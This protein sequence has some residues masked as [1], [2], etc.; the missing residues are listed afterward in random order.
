M[1]MNRR[2]TLALLGSA[3]V[4]AAARGALAATPAQAGPA[5]NAYLAA[6]HMALAH[7]DPSASDV[8]P[9]PAPRGVFE[10]DLRQCPRVVGGPVNILTAASTSPDYMWAISSEGVAYVDVRGGGF[11]EVARA[12][13]PGVPHISAE[14]HDKVLGA[15]FASLEQVEA[16]VRDGYGA[17]WTRIA[18]GVYSLVDRDNVVF[19]NTRVGVVFAF[20][21]A[22]PANPAAG[23]QILR[24]RD[25]RPLLGPKETLAGM[26]LTYDGKLVV[27]GSRSLMVIDRSLEGEPVRVAFGDDERISNSVCIDERNAIYVASDKLMRKVVWTGARLSLDE[28]D[29]AWSSPYDGGRQPP[30]IKTGTGTG[31]TPTLMGFGADPDKLVVITDGADR[32]K[33]VAFWRDDIPA[34]AKPVAGARSRRIAGQIQVTCELS[35]LPEFIQ[36]EQ[37]VVV[38]GYGAFVVNNISQAKAAPNLMVGVVALGPVLEPPKGAER[39]EWNPSKQSFRS[40]WRRPD[41]VSTS[42]VPTLSGP[43]GVVMVN[44]YTAK[45]G[46]EVTGMDWTTGAT[47]TRAIFGHDNLGNGAYALVQLFPNGDLLFNSIAGPIRAASPRKNRRR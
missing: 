28:A 43:S 24:S 23:V 47:V 1:S 12:A 9:Y 20:G 42:M 40:V 21:L 8:M 32:M 37:S 13:A 41:L 18:N 33:L 25:F 31:S 29:G 44:G 39:F 30:Q 36:T 46:W 3:G 38:S 34:R 16:R 35:P 14:T 19:Y 27:I 22:D 11:R 45:D 6:P 15:P 7:F 10:V 26:S 2:S 17:D 5:P 4:L